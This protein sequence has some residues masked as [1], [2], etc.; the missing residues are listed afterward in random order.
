M[1]FSSVI[2]YADDTKTSISN[3]C[4]RKVIERLEKD[5]INVLKFMASNGLVA[6]SKKTSLLILGL[7]NNNTDPIT[8]KI[9]KESII[10]ETHAKLLGMTMDEKQ[11]WKN[12]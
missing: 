10:Q 3:R 7:K 11:G 5:A 2:T 9:G 4:I 1:E 8:I 12:M 6:N